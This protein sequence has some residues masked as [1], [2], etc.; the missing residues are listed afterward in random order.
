ML[1]DCE[2]DERALEMTLGQM[3]SRSDL[4]PEALLEDVIDH[5]VDR[6]DQ[7]GTHYTGTDHI[8]LAL[9]QNPH[10]AKLLQQHGVNLEQLLA[11]IYRDLLPPSC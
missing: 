5:A 11:A 6:A 9:A 4:T 8:L 2:L 1:R 10:G 7:L 3:A